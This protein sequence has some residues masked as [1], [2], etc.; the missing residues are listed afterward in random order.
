MSNQA[1]GTLYDEEKVDWN[2]LEKA[3]ITKDS[4]RSNND[5]QPFLN[6]RKTSLITIPGFKMGSLSS[7]PING[8]IHLQPNADTPDKLDIKFTYARRKLEIP[9][10]IGGYTFSKKDHQKLTKEGHLGKLVPLKDGAGN[11]YDAFVSV[12]RE[13]NTIEVLPHYKMNIPNKILGVE[14]QREQIKGLESG[15]KIR[16]DGMV[17]KKYEEPFSAVL[18]VNAATA[19]ISF[20]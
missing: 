7:G 4:L 11:Q 1:R 5:L 10:E 18:Q 14:L 20:N 6:G 8:K 15:Q 16:V 9:D 12:D 19:K 3:G 13:T 2:L 17:S